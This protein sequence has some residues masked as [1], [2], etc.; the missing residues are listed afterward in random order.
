MSLGHAYC[1][2]SVYRL[3]VRDGKVVKQ[4]LVCRR[5]NAVL[6][7]GLNQLRDAMLGTSWQLSAI[8][9]GSSGSPVVASQTWGLSPL[10]VTE[11]TVSRQYGA[12]FRATL[13]LGED[14]LNG[15]TIR[16]IWI[17]PST[18]A[19]PSGAKA[20]ARVVIPDLVKTSD[21][22]YIFQFDCS[23]GGENSKL[24]CNMLAALADS[25]G[26][27]SFRIASLM[28]GRGSAAENVN[29]TG[30]ADPWTMTPIALAGS[31]V[32]DGELTLFFTLPPDQYNGLVLVEGG[33]Y[34]DVASGSSPVSVPALFARGLIEP[35]PFMVE[36]GKGAQVVV[37]LRWESG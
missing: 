15:S 7:S 25:E 4:E 6:T 26:A 11:P 30:L 10:L 19:P 17:A 14:E 24:A 34:F 16:E 28:C 5:H 29:D 23:W 13:Q 36:V 1:N 37:Q 35:G 22:A 2:V 18:T 8:G 33:V 31:S 3:T 20:Y 9:L 27:Y 12:Q 32:A 21:F